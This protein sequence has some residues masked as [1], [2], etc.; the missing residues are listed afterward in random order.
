MIANKTL[1]NILHYVAQVS[2]F[3][4]STDNFPLCPQPT[5]ESNDTV[6]LFFLNTPTYYF[7]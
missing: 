5:L 7:L 1:P 6:V 2:I 4:S 3:P